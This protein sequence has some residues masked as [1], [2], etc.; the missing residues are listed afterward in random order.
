MKFNAPTRSCRSW[1]LGSACSSRSYEN[2]V[3]VDPSSCYWELFFL[4]FF[5]FFSS[6]GW[7]WNFFCVRKILMLQLSSWNQWRFLH[8]GLGEVPFCKISTSGCIMSMTWKFRSLDSFLSK[9][10][11]WNLGLTNLEL[12]SYFEI[13]DWRN[14]I[15]C[16]GVLENSGNCQGWD[17]WVLEKFGKC[18]GWGLLPSAYGQN[19]KLVY[20]FHCREK[21]ILLIKTT[22]TVVF[23][24]LNEYLWGMGQTGGRKEA[25]KRAALTWIEKYWRSSSLLS[26]INDKMKMLAHE[27]CHDP[28]LTTLLGADFFARILFKS[29]TSLYRHSET[30]W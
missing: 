1:K 28:Q 18:Q 12:L 30:G 2:W 29:Y 3:D 27:Y 24:A 11:L 7:V 13:H 4:F 21:K 23:A 15:F 19:V 8:A 14:L 6:L 10:G 20:Y 22:H 26:F 5:S 17:F 16:G 9:A 25:S